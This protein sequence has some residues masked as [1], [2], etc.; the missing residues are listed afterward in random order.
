MSAQDRHTC[1]GQRSR[2]DRIIIG[3]ALSGAV[4]AIASWLLGHYTT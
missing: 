4:R 1:L 2:W 3:S